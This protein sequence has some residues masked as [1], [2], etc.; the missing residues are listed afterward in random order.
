MI[1]TL[2]RLHTITQTHILNKHQ[3]KGGTKFFFENKEE[4]G[5]K[6]TNENQDHFVNFAGS[7]PL[8]GVIDCL[9]RSYPFLLKTQT[10]LHN[11]ISIITFTQPN[12]INNQ[13]LFYSFSLCAHTTTTTTTTKNKKKN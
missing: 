13:Q 1:S 11:Y 3:S 12:N 2:D 5:R 6:E 7:N 10:Q 8:N 4:E 9:S